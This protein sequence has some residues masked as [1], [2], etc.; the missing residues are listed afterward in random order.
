MTIA[1]TMTTTSKPTYKTT[2]KD[3]ESL[4]FQTIIDQLAAYAI[5]EQAKTLALELMPK[6]NLESIRE[7][8][9]EITEAV[10]VLSM[11]GTPPLNRQI[12]IRNAIDQIERGYVLSPA[13]LHECASFLWDVEKLSSFLK[14]KYEAAPMLSG[15]GDSL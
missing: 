1:T 13:A 3:F 9:R 7:S 6:T 4:E 5:S 12:G 2:A 14:G 15:Y 10:A 8:H 11:G